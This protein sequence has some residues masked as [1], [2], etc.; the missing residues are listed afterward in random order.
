MAESSQDNDVLPG[1]RGPTVHGVYDYFLGGAGHLLAD[2]ELA[3]AIEERFPDVPAHVQAARKFHLDAARWCAGQRIGRF[4]GVG[5]A[6]WKPGVLNIH[7]AARGAD[8]VYVHRSRAAHALAGAML[9]GPGTCSVRARV[10]FPAEVLS[11]VPVADMLAKGGPVSLH[12]GMTLHFASPAEARE[13]VAV[14]AGTLPRGSALVVSV[15]LVDSSP[16]GDELT[17]MFTPAPVY[18]HTAGDVAGWLE[19][20]GLDLV[21]PGVCDVA[22]LAPGRGWEQAGQAARAAGATVGALGRKP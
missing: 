5:I 14:Y 17:G 16:R 3:K 2:R 9:A 12:L 21:P 18:R 22:R 7:D 20:A 8:A 1:A 10:N 6:S 13:Q 19:G 11:A 15:A 4:I